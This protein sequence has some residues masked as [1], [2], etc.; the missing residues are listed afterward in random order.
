MTDWT[1]HWSSSAN[2]R[3]GEEMWNT[4]RE[5]LLESGLTAAEFGGSWLGAGP[6]DPLGADN[7]WDVVDATE[8]QAC[9][10]ANALTAAL[11]RPVSVTPAKAEV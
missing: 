11:A 8:Q 7:G 6:D 5:I 2:E 9:D 3:Y 10:L 4:A 1:L